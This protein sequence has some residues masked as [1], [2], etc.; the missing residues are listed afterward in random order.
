MKI[1][2][3]MLAKNFDGRRVP[4]SNR[5]YGQKGSVIVCEETDKRASNRHS[6]ATDKK[7]MPLQ[8]SQTITL[9]VKERGE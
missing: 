2:V 7:E 1:R 9:E 5:S 4:P 8:K 6:K 3:L